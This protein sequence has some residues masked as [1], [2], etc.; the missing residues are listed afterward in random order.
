MNIETDE[1]RVRLEKGVMKRLSID[2]D[3]GDMYLKRIDAKLIDI[4]ADEG[5]VDLD[6]NILR[7]GRYRIYTDEGDVALNIPETVELSV[8]LE[9]EDGRI[10]TDFELEIDELD[11]GERVRGKI[12]R[13]GAK[14]EVSTDEGN[15]SLEKR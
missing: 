1:G 12:G 3:E 8:F 13:G 5:D 14:L 6:M 10:D 7:N 15:I 9:A 4:S 2:C 11:D